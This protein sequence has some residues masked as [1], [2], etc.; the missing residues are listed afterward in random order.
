MNTKYNQKEIN[1]KAILLLILL[2]IAIL[3]GSYAITYSKYNNLVKINSKTNVAKWSV[4]VNDIDITNNQ[5][6][7]L[8]DF[9]WDNSQSTA[10]DNTIA[11]GSRGNEKLSISNNSDVDVTINITSNGL[12]DINN[13]P[14]DNKSIKVTPSENTF[15]I[16]KGESKT[17]QINIEWINIEDGSNDIND[18]FIAKNFNEIMIPLEIN[19]SQVIERG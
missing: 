9:V 2:L 16:K 6:L 8:N 19:A 5:N 13:N 10:K 4:L 1:K 11:P 12:I 3:T 15:I 7:D 18:T 17:I 14:I